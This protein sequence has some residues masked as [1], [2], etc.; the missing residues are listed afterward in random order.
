MEVNVEYQEKPTNTL[1]VAFA[2]GTPSTTQPNR[3]IGAVACELAR[4]H[5]CAV[6]TQV[7]VP[8]SADVMCIPASEMPGKPP[9]MLRLCHEAMRYA[10]NRGITAI[11]VVAGFPH[12][13][14][15]MRDLKIA[16]AEQNWQGEFL[17]HAWMRTET[18]QEHWFVPECTQWRTRWVWLW[19][20]R[21][22]ALHL[23]MELWSSLYKGLVR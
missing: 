7:D 19:N 21:E 20:V 2:F 11:H 14:R 22:L 10:M 8:L 6:F 13:P 12:M 9:R 23:L 15:V 16:K 5:G 17:H 18:A 1:V 4:E 3:R